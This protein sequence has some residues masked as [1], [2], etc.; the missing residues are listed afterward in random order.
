MVDLEAIGVVTLLSVL[1]DVL[2][3]FLVHDASLGIAAS[4]G[5]AAV[6]SCVEVLVIWQFR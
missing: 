1:N 4:S 6:P 3:G 5:L 2:V